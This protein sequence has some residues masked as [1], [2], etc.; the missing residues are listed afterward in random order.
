MSCTYTGCITSPRL[1]LHCVR[2]IRVPF[3]I[4]LRSG[5]RGQDAKLAQ[6]AVLGRDSVLGA[7]TDV[8]EG[9]QVCL[10][11]Q[12]FYPDLHGAKKDAVDRCTSYSQ[13]QQCQ[14]QQVT[15]LAAVALWLVGST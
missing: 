7:G 8:G 14:D 13:L 10:Q 12:M 5:C 11:L 6:T 9:S 2:K 15:D 4:D 3:W 1:L